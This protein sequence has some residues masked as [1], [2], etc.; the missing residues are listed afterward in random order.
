ML[1]G[2]WRGKHYIALKIKFLYNQIGGNIY[3]LNFKYFVFPKRYYYI[4]QKYK[5]FDFKL[6]FYLF[7]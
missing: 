4:N 5:K 1:T 3:L 7:N 2:G 6:C